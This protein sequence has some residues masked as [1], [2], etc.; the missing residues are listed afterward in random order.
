MQFSPCWQCDDFQKNRITIAGKKLLV[1]L[2]PQLYS[3]EFCFSL[4]CYMYMRLF[5]GVCFTQNCF[6]SFCW[7]L[8]KQLFSTCDQHQRPSL[9]PETFRSKVQCTKAPVKQ[10][11]M[12]DDS[13]RTHNSITGSL[14]LPCYAS[15]AA[16]LQTSLFLFFPA[17][18]DVNL[19]LFVTMHILV[20]C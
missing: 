18:C 9:E 4:S 13:L 20:D 6:E 11:S 15:V 16:C 10:R 7:L 17:F 14:Q 8:I 2:Q 12:V 5:E 3:Q 19:R 1:L